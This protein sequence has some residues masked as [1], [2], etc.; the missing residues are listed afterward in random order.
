MNYLY[1]IIGFMFVLAIGPGLME[2]MGDSVKKSILALFF[3]TLI[4]FL[5]IIFLWP[6]FGIIAIILI[7]LSE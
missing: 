1:F 7:L 6:I 4:I 3:I 2:S 5:L